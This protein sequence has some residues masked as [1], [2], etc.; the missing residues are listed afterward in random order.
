[1]R[2]LGTAGSPQQPI[3]Q[4]IQ[5]NTRTPSEHRDL[6]QLSDR[7]SKQTLPGNPTNVRE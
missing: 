1:M 3:G 5:T 2:G 4:H 7:P 6:P